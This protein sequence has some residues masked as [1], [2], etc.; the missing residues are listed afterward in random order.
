MIR[1]QNSLIAE[2]KKVFVVQIDH[3]RHNIALS[4][5][6]IQSKALT[7]FNSVKVE[8]GEEAAEEKCEASRDSFMMFE[9]RN[10]ASRPFA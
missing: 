5:S 4:Q 7:L 2:M 6:L 1:E 9:V 10:L 3:T 8:R